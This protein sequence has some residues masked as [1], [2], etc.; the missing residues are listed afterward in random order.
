MEVIP[1]LW[2]LTPPVKTLPTA[3]TVYWLVNIFDVIVTV[4]L[5]LQI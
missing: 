5:T 2:S 4:R 3:N 1:E